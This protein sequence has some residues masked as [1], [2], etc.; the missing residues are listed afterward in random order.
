MEA[1]LVITK[2]AWAMRR[3]IPDGWGVGLS[4]CPILFLHLHFYRQS[5][6]V[7]IR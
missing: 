3:S 1:E 7:C 2:S 4:S 6:L 5:N